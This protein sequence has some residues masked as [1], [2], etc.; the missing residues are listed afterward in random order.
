MARP[1]ASTRAVLPRLVPFALAV[2]LASA[3]GCTGDGQTPDC[4]ALDSGCYAP[5][6]QDAAADVSDAG[7]SDASTADSSD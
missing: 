5:P 7:A 1:L 3:P 4:T 2:T 6:V